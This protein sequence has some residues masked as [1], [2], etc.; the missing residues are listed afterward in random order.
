MPAKTKRS[1][2]KVAAYTPRPFE[3]RAPGTRRLQLLPWNRS[4]VPGAQSG[5]WSQSA[6]GC[7]R[8]KRSAAASS[9]STGTRSRR[10]GR[11][12]RPSG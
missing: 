2:A 8:S 7:S 5:W 11:S 3:R 9:E 1:A 4:S 12:P 10:P 6:R